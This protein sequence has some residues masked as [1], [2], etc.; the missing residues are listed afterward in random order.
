M[1]GLTILKFLGAYPDPGS[2]I[3]L[4][5]D[6]GSGIEK[7]GSAT[8][9]NITTFVQERLKIAK[10]FGDR[11]AE[12]R[13]HS[14]LGNA[15]IFLGEF[16]KAAEHYKQTLLLA[17]VG[18]V[19]IPFPRI[20]EYNW[21]AH[22][23]GRVP[24]AQ[25]RSGPC[26]HCRMSGV[27]ASLLYIRSEE[28]GS[29]QRKSHLKNYNKS[30]YVVYPHVLI[31]LIWS[32]GLKGTGC[33]PPPLYARGK[34]GRSHLNE[35]ITPLLFTGIGERFSQTQRYTEINHDPVSL[36]LRKVYL[37]FHLSGQTISNLRHAALLR[38][39]EL[40]L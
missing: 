25:G 32:E 16:E 40:P 24:A 18:T 22:E 26:V 11:S 3:F 30:L 10:E 4:T 20:R 35:E 2:E 7:F 39:C 15:H 27:R 8:L 17:Q 37:L 13:A 1:V 9:I 38:R 29:M 23:G 6:P 28:L 34:A 14:N 36:V 12:R 5:L 19:Y 21:I 33:R 31:Y